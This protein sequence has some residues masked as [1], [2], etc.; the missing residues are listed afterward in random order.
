MKASTVLVILGVAAIGGYAVYK[1]WKISNGEKSADTEITTNV[2]PDAPVKPE[3]KEKLKAEE[4]FEDVVENLEAEKSDIQNEIVQ[5]HEAAAK[6][7]KDSM[8]HILAEETPNVPSENIN[9][10]NEIDD[11]L[12]KLL[13]E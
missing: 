10:L 13:D 7:M 6:I 2:M 4:T 3:S 9:D 5:R 11:A 8:E 12:D 1:L